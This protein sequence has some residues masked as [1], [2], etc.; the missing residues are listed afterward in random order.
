MSDVARLG[1]VVDASGAQREIRLTR[2]EL[3]KLANG[4]TLAQKA[5]A[6]VA[7]PLTQTTVAARA[8][9]DGF[10]KLRG[11]LTQIA[12]QASGIPG[13]LGRVASLLGQFSVGSAL[14][15]GVLAGIGAIGFAWEKATEKSRKAREEW[16]KQ[17]DLLQKI[18]REQELGL[19]GEAGAA[20]RSGRARLGVLAGQIADISGRDISNARKMTA[21]TPL[22]EEYTR[23]AL[24]VQAGEKDVTER[25]RKDAEERADIARREVEKRLALYQE[26]ADARKRL[27]LDIVLAALYPTITGKPVTGTNRV[28]LQEK[29]SGNQ[30]NLKPADLTDSLNRTA[31]RYAAVFEKIAEEDR[32]KA[33]TRSLAFGGGLAIAGQ[34]AGQMGGPF[35]G[36]ATGALSAVAA[37]AGPMGIA[38]SAAQGLVSAIFDMGGESQRAAERM[39]QFR[40]SVQSFV[41]SMGVTTG[42]L[43]NSEAQR[44]QAERQFQQ[45][46]RA[47][48]Q[49][50]LRAQVATGKPGAWET[51]E[52]KALRELLK[53]MDADYAAWIEAIEK[54][55][56]ALTTASRNAPRGFFAESYMGPYSPSGG[57]PRDPRTGSDPR[58]PGATMV[59]FSGSVTFNITNPDPVVAAQQVVQGLRIVGLAIAGNGSTNSDVLNLM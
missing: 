21:I 15:V 31:V 19:P 51:P 53:Q 52:V 10:S 33:L 57:A 36:A 35:G 11:P 6:G 17:L 44:R 58:A 8:A 25:V 47:V 32:Q 22:A 18:R 49:E 30:W 2:E 26:L 48:E 27:D 14:T 42:R 12:V 46:R 24:A 39:T 56:E 54:N 16:E 37:G 13:P 50:I 55:T 20:V 4:G 5:V 38:A 7:Q 1:L 34:F 3:V 43:S 41:D 45:E 40:E 59:P 23:I 28:D 9:T 29:L